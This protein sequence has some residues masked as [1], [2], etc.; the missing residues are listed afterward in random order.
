MKNII[1]G[2]AAVLLLS[3]CATLQGNPELRP[4]FVTSAAHDI[5]AA[6]AT[7]PS[8]LF[9]KAQAS[10][11]DAHAKLDLG[12]AM[13][14]GRLVPPA[15]AADI[16]AIADLEARLD[17]RIDAYLATHSGKS[18]AA[19]NWQKVLAPTPDDLAL[20]DRYLRHQSPDYWLTRA[21]LSGTSQ[22]LFIYAPPACLKC[23]GGVMPIDSTR[24]D[25]DGNLI[26]TAEHCLFAVRHYLGRSPPGVAALPRAV[27]YLALPGVWDENARIES[28]LTQPD[29]KASYQIGTDACGTSDAFDHD[30]TLLAVESR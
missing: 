5:E 3:G 16:A 25:I 9:D 27:R 6:L 15:S 17:P 18:P 26:D 8:D 19:V 28:Q 22:T 29:P 12:L 2:I 24:Y 23:T 20:I 10:D 30:L 7:P 4:F 11:A 13:W 21:R 14:A 1:A